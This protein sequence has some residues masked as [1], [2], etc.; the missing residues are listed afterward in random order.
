MRALVAWLAVLVAACGDDLGPL[1]VEV[2][3]GVA[4]GSDDGNGVQ[5]WLGLPYAKAPMGPLRWK[6]PQRAESWDGTRDAT[7][8]GF[9]CPQTTVITP[10][11][12][13]EDCLVLNV[14]TPSP[15]PATPIPVMVWIHGG[16]FIFGAGSDSFYSGAE[17]ARTRGVVVVT[18]NY[19]LGGLG[20]LAHPAL[21]AEDPK[22]P[23]SGNYGLL[24][25][26]AALEWVQRNIAAF[27]GDPEK[28][29]LFGESAGG[30][31]TCVHY[32]SRATEP[33]FANA[34][35]QSG[36][37]TAGGLEQTREQAEADGIAT[38]ER[39]GC[40]GSDASALACMRD[41]IDF[42]VLDAT[43]L[44]PITQQQPG[45][46]FYA[47]Y[48]PSTLP[49]VDGIV[50]PAPIEE[51]FAA[52]DFPPRPLIIGTNGDEGQLF[53]SNIL[54]NLVMTEQEYLDALTRRFGSP[55]AGM[56]AARYAA[57]SF[58]TPNDALAAVSTDA[59]F[60]C[61]ARRNAKAI[62]AAGAPVYRYTF[63]RTLEQPL[64]A[65]LGAFHS[66]DIAFVFGTE[67]FPL[68]KVGSATALRDAMQTYWTEHAKTGA[69]G[70]DWP[71]FDASET[72]RVLDVPLSTTANYK[73][74]DCD[75]WN[76]L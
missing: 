20:F 28:V 34:I 23:T 8:P 18:I 45:G 60:I 74:A 5:S 30:F 41:V 57:A 46:F 53:H 63:E 40:P 21:A 16:A 10:G 67:T 13:A 44:P 66:A 48:P 6:P 69:P 61:P 65:D 56:I 15:R 35:I 38:A 71:Q 64:I 9:K 27:G 7:K 70:A 12:G 29:T 42:A 75:F 11:G 33:L 51:R 36:A 3:T 52:G 68:G 39:L 43:A 31:S 59:F 26:V 1:D 72:V 19:R 37:C 73:V 58:P 55:K 24:D 17:L 76:G 50:L 4:R 32:A 62:V 14:W 54:S 25:Q 49:N 22:H 2:E 47:N